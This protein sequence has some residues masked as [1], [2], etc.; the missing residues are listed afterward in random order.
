[1]T[2]ALTG[3]SMSRATGIRFVA[4]RLAWSVAVLWVVLTA[5]WVILIAFP[6][7]RYIGMV[8]V[9]M[10]LAKAYETLPGPFAIYVDLVRRLFTFQWGQSTFYG[11]PV[12]DLYLRRLPVTL[13]YVVPGVLASVL[14]GTGVSTYA[15]I[16]PEGWLSRA[17]SVASSVGLSLPAFVLAAVFFLYMPDY[18][19][20][21]RIYD[22]SLG[23]WHPRNLLHLTV[24]AGIVA[25]NFSAVQVRHA[26]GE[27]VEYLG[28]E[29][30]KM[31][32]AK[33]A[34]RLRVARHIF[35]NA[36][37]SLASLVLGEA[38]GVLLLSTVVIETVFE[39]PGI[40]VAVFNGFATGDPMVSFTA[41]F[42]IVLLGVSGTLA[43]DFARFLLDPRL[44]Q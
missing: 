39:M 20:W 41:V 21:I 24:P 35:R 37:P 22:A 2:I 44:D 26:Q 32:R 9:E 11:K 23:L 4:R 36:W 10:G 25:L 14:V 15:A 3:V 40:V 31:A 28:T 29:F 38:L 33:G 8:E 43:R 34:G 30:V 13:V 18:L 12:V 1:M 27:T 6:N 17:L 19:G 7:T 5:M 16:K 42:G